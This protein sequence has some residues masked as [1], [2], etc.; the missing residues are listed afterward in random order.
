MG[1][2]RPAW[3]APP[4]LRRR[5]PEA[6]AAWD[7]SPEPVSAPA[8]FADR[9]GASTFLWM[10]GRRSRG[11]WR[12]ELRRLGLQLRQ[13]AVQVV[14]EADPALRGAGSAGV[15]PTTPPL[16]RRHGPEAAAA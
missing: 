3:A 4:L 7:P 15:A 10:G 11:A 12:S 14:G 13:H 6:P 2:G 1:G 9:G 8:D 5:G 16:L